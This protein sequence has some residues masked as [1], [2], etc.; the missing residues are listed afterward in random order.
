MNGHPQTGRFSRFMAGAL[1]WAFGGY[2]SPYEGAN[3]SQA[4]GR[5]PGAAP[6]DAKR[7]LAPSVRT[8][9]VRRSRYLS[10]N[11]GFVREL[12]GDMAIYS[13]GDGIRPQAQSPDPEWNRQAEAYFKSWSA[14]CEVTGRF[15]F[16]ECQSIVCRGVDI[17]GEYFVLKTRD[18]VGEPVIQL[19]EAHRVGEGDRE[20]TV[21]GIGLDAAGRPQ[22]YR[23]LED[24]GEGID[25]PAASVLHVFEPESAS[26]VRAAPVI[27][28]SIN[29]VLDEMELL[30]LEKHAVK[31]NCDIARVL[32][33]PR[34]L[35]DEDTGDFQIGAAEI[36]SSDPVSL[37]KIVGGKLVALKPGEELD[38]FQSGRPSPTFTGFLEHL[39]R[40]SALGVLP[41]E[42]AADSSRIGGAGV[43]LVV[44]KADRR[45]SFRQ[46]VL[47]GRFLTPVWAYVI[48]DAIERGLLPNVPGWHKIACT[49]P[50]RVSVDA[51]REAQQNR[52][53]VEM[54][55]KTLSDHFAELGAEFGEEL[56]RRARDAK[57][58]LETAERWE[59]PVEMLYR[60]ASGAAKSAPVVPDA[61]QLSQTSAVPGKRSS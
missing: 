34:D 30:A 54:G 44:A 61:D 32:K 42:F 50:K 49:C 5:V 1:R 9:L 48:G 58:I 60:P 16:E 56:E 25:V 27:Q 37:Q 19:I 45:F 46:M 20:G 53:D 35:T 4:R 18:A 52:A 14:R 28:H 8:E 11:S 24:D 38:S 15:S 21:D 7:D 47:I 39:R 12:V 36:G 22:F 43:R 31:D 23:I 3:Q 51:G 55:L 2:G 33:S 13:T 57:M 41:F 59:V 26:A 17:D 40:D 6:G 10:K 29:N